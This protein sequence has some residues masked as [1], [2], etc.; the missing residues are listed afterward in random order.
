VPKILSHPGEHLADELNAIGMSANELARQ[1]GIPTNRLTQIIAGKRG[2][3]GD[4][5]LRLG[6]WFG[7]GPDIWMNLQK[8]YELRL[9]EQEIGDGLKK[10][11][12]YRAKAA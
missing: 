11:P 3:T 1:I 5:A 4:T 8:N 6:R 10:I 2:I 7:T 9:A 12:R